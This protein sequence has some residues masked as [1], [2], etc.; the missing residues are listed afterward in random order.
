[1]HLFFRNHNAIR[2]K[3]RKGKGLVV[4]SYL[5]EPF[6]GLP[7]SDARGH[8]NWQ[9]CRAIAATWQSYGYSVDI[10]D[11]HDSRYRPPSNTVAV[12]DIH[13]N[14]E[15]WNAGLPR[16]CKKVL[17][18][19]GAHW[20]TQNAA[21][22]LRLEAIR[23]RRGVSLIPRRQ[24]PPNRAGECA[25]A[26]T[27]LGNKFT[28]D[29]W[30]FTGTPIH[31]IPISCAVPFSWPREKDWKSCRRRFLWAGSYGMAHKGLD[32]VLEAFAKMPE[33]HLTVCGR[34]EKE[35]DFFNAY[36]KELL[37]TENIHC[38][39]WIEAGSENFVEVCRTHCAMVYPS[40]SE[41]GGG[42]LIHAMA[43]G[44]VPLATYEASVDLA[45]FGEWIEKPTVE[46]VQKAVRLLAAE[47]ESLMEDRAR[48]AWLHTQKN[49]SI[50][51]FK[52]TYASF[53]ETLMRD[54]DSF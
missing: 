34:P 26:I 44:L 50:E 5:R 9:E 30:A 35:A 45:D 52:N 43:G 40:C 39:G 38:A 7:E 24:S 6:L 12:I 3:G 51:A 13:Q 17:H 28:Q 25:H 1:M 19:T 33:F 46:G 29:T 36:R 49:H 11:W 23:D 54:E 48:R 32:L 42:A 18:A 37:H 22:Y 47:S 4:L 41:G 53:V 16:D 31:R 2:L 15:Q 27:V 14:L 8:T 10:V 20:L 21:E